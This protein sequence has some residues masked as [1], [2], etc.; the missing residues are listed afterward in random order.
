MYPFDV[1][2]INVNIINKF[3]RKV[4]ISYFYFRIVAKFLRFEIKA[5]G[6]YYLSLVKLKMKLENNIAFH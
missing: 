5:L 1:R 6:M 3:T 2:P 4:C